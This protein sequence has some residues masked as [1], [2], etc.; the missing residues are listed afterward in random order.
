[1]ML[2]KTLATSFTALALA[3]IAG[4]VASADDGIS[5]KFFNENNAANCTNVETA[6]APVLSSANVNQDCSR[7][8]R[9]NELDIDVHGFHHDY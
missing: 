6:S 7:N 4:G 3:G 2:K 9:H 1:M 8:F 5:S